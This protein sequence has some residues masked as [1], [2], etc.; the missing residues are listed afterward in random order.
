[1]PTQGDP[2]S[3]DGR[4]R[5]VGETMDRDIAGILVDG[6][7]DRYSPSHGDGEFYQ[8]FRRSV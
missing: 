7:L 4:G 6:S 3:Q 2:E 1:M 5:P 8:Q